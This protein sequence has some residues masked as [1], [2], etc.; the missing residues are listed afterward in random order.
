MGEPGE[1]PSVGSHGVGHNSSDLAA[2]AAARCPF[3]TVH[4][5]LT[6]STLGWFAIPS[7]SGSR[8]VRTL[9]YD[10]SVLGGPAQHDS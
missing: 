4:E 7:S 10:P 6:A 2:A 3:F 5:V 1:L 9:C 8:F